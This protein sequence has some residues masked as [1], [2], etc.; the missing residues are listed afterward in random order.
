M[1][2]VLYWLT[3][4]GGF[5][6]GMPYDF[7]QGVHKIIP[8]TTFDNYEKIIGEVHYYGE[9]GRPI[10]H[11]IP[12]TEKYIIAL[13][14]GEIRNGYI[15]DY[16]SSYDRVPDAISGVYMMN[17]E[18]GEP[19]PIFY[20]KLIILFVVGLIVIVLKKRRKKMKEDSGEA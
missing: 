10:L 6:R 16:F 11:S 8:W 12:I 14:W 9:D 17:L 13:N 19:V 7:V 4:V 20:Y 3:S 5:V 1:V 18:T 2:C 15:M